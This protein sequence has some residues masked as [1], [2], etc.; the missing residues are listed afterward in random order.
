[1]NSPLLNPGSELPLTHPPATASKAIERL[2][3]T[4]SKIQR[5]AA[6]TFVR[7]SNRIGH[8]IMHM[9]NM[10]KHYIV[11]ASDNYGMTGDGHPRFLNWPSEFG[12]TKDYWEEKQT[13]WSLTKCYTYLLAWKSDSS[14]LE[15]EWNSS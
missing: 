3:F 8:H 12:A 9:T 4:I 15:N 6:A 1:L 2:F 5:R 14:L 11:T 10:A 7:I 13:A